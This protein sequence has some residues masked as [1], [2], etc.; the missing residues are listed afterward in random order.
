MRVLSV[1]SSILLAVSAL[2]IAAQPRQPFPDEAARELITAALLQYFD[3]ASEFEVAASGATIS[4]NILSLDEVSIVG[5]PAILRGFSGHLT[6]HITGLQ[7]DMT[8][9]TTSQIRVLRVGRAT[10]VA[11]S[12]ARAVEEGLVKAS[13]AIQGPRIRFNGGQFEARATVRRGESIYP[14]QVTGILVVERKQRVWVRILGVQVSGGDA[15]SNLIERELA[16]IN[17]VLDLSKWPLNLFIQRLTLHH[18]TI[19]LLATH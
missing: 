14:A 13:S 5:K 17:P 11:R 4:G 10:V 19:Q 15:P 9:V 2:P 16:K 12:T 8:S 3:P 7:L 6:A 18:D 1:L